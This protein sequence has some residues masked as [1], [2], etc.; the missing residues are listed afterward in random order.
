MIQIRNSKIKF[1][2]GHYLIV[3][4]DRTDEVLMY[5]FDNVRDILTFMG[6]AHT[7]ENSDKI[8]HYIT[9]AL[10]RDNHISRFLTGETLR[11]YIIDTN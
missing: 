9:R 3:F 8:H 10:R 11:L 1:Y 6:L 4:Y 2:K 7:K 5:M